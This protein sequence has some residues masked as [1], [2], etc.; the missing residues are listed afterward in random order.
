MTP[1]PIEGGCFC[2]ALRYRLAAAPIASMICHCATCRRVAAAP[3]V[4]WVTVAA[5][6]FAYTRGTPARLASSAGVQRDFCRDCGS[7]VTYVRASAP[8]EVDVTTCSLDEPSAFPPTYHAWLDH[9]LAWLDASVA[10]PRFARSRSD[11]PD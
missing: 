7:H 6:D 2:G 3:T 11:L 8:A 1:A 10:L 9:D 4:A 5:R